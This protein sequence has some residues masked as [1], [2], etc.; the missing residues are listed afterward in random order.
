MRQAPVAAWSAYPPAAPGQQQVIIAVGRDAG[1]VSPIVALLEHGPSGALLDDAFV[2][3]D[4]IP[5]RLDHEVL[6]PMSQA[7][8]APAAVPVR[9][10]A[11]AV[12]HALVATLQEGRDVPSSGYQPVAAR[13]RRALIDDIT[14]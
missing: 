14:R 6:A 3:P 8:L 10:A 2:L 5:A 4:M 1:R 11:E 7:G 12:W 9:D 13:L